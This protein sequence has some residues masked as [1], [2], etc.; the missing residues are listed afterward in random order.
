MYYHSI[1]YNLF[2]SET[3]YSTEITS[4]RDL[5]IYDTKLIKLT[6]HLILSVLSKILNT[7][8]FAE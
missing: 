6:N 2:I 3:N 1:S 7:G 4:P 8:H 5:L